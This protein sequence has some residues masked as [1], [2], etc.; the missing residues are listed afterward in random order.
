MGVV[1][2][3]G[4]LGASVANCLGRYVGP[5]PCHHCSESHRYPFN[6][7]YGECD[8]GVVSFGTTGHNCRLGGGLASQRGWPHF[9][10]RFNVPEK[11]W[12]QIEKRVVPNLVYFA[13]NY[14]YVTF[15]VFAYFL[16]VARP[17]LSESRSFVA[18][19]FDVNFPLDPSC[20]FSRPAFLLSVVLSFVVFVLASAP[21]RELQARLAPYLP[22]ENHRLVVAAIIGAVL[23]T[24]SGSLLLTVGLLCIS[25]ILVLTHALLRPVPHRAQASH[26]ATRMEV[27]ARSQMDA[28]MG[29]ERQSEPQQQ[30]QQP[31]EDIEGNAPRDVESF[32]HQGVA[33]E[34]SPHTPAVPSSGMA[35]LPR[36]GVGASQRQRKAPNSGGDGN[37]SGIG[38]GGGGGNNKTD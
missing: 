20:R 13:T 31:E 24:I 6:E 23:I 17:S 18:L 3:L 4:E 1:D 25:A 26:T 7:V 5:F 28:F 27:A 36:P 2:Q 38:I 15:A 32:G 22:T 19:C 9:L 11:N 37:S 12:A 21:P 8:V 30:E 16:C 10:E 14:V 33:G 29:Q 35:N 34:L